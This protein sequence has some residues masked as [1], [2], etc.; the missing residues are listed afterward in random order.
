MRLLVAALTLLLAG[1]ATSSAT[2]YC[3]VETLATGA[4]PLGLI[5]L[6]S[7]LENRLRG[8][9]PRPLRSGYLCWY[10]AGEN[11]VASTRQDENATRLGYTL[12]RENGTWKLSELSPKILALPHEIE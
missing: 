5:R 3:A 11:L 2:K 6:D 1:C 7:D 12:L 10:V 8:Q 4:M 9:L